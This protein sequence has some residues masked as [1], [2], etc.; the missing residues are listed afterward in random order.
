MRLLILLVFSVVFCL[1]TRG[2]AEE[3]DR[4]KPNVL[5]MMVDD[6]GFSDIGCFGGEIQTPNLDRLAKNGVRMTQFYNCAKCETTRAT[7]LSGR[8]YPEVGNQKLEN[9]ITLAEGM[10]L[11]GYRTIMTGKWHLQDDPIARGF[12]QYFGHLSGATNFF[13]GDDTFRLGQQKFEVPKQGFYTTDAN[14]DYAIQFLNQ[15][16][17]SRQPFFLYIAFNAPHYPLQAPEADVK[18]YIGQYRGGWDRM[19]AARFERQKAMGLW[20]QGTQLSPRP[21][22]VAAWDSLTAKQQKHEDL[23]MATFAG[24]VDRVDQN[25]GRLL[26]Y[27]ESKNE[28]DNTLIL[29]LS[30]NGAC[31]FQ[32]SKP[33][34]IENRLKPWD[35][36]S[37][38]TYDK[39]WAHAG[40]TPFREYKQ[41]QHEGGINTPFIAHWPKGISKD[42]NGSIQREPAHLVDVLPTLLDVANVDYPSSYGDTIV[43]PKR[44]LSLLPAFQGKS[45]QRKAPLAFSFYGKN[46]ALRKGKWKIVNKNFM[47]FE[48]FD[49]SKD[50]TELN[51]LSKS[52]PEKFQEM[53]QAM[54]KLFEEIGIKIKKKSGKTNKKQGQ[55]KKNR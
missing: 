13:I 23:M 27:L 2:K 34:S 38:W 29:F 49:L 52:N 50:R 3:S 16:A 37:Y 54:K 39:G 17:T 24:M 43:G 6:L 12:E 18:K 55:V 19:R 40:N 32:R 21:S 15:T 4:A 30:D 46:N 1:S 33:P 20:P 22:D 51:D 26:T 48:L 36:D 41:N 31:P 53:S 44:G 28:L 45:L 47:D 9:C 10:K 7:L 25:I 11:G 8:Y 14:V 35:P 5:L 42:L